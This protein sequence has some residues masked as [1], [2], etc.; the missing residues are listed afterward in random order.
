MKTK[1]HPTNENMNIITNKENINP[2]LNY[3]PNKPNLLKKNTKENF[4]DEMDQLLNADF[5]QKNANR[6]NYPQKLNPSKNKNNI[7][8]NPFGINVN[9]NKG[10]NNLTNFDSLMNMMNN[11]D[12]M[13]KSK[14]FDLLNKGS[15]SNNIINSNNLMNVVNQPKQENK[16]STIFST[17][18]NN[19]TN[20]FFSNNNNI[21]TKNV[22]L[23]NNNIFNK[24]NIDLNNLSNLGTETKNRFLYNNANTS[25]ANIAKNSNS[26]LQLLNPNRPEEKNQN[27]KIENLDIINSYDVEEVFGSEL[28]SKKPPSPSPSSGDDAEKSF[29]NQSKQVLM[30]TFP[31]SSIINFP[32][33]NR[34]QDECFDLLYRTDERALITSPTGSGKTLLFELGIGRIIKQ[35]Y[36]IK[37][38]AYKNK[39]FKIIYIAPI[40]S[41]CQE[42]TFEWKMKYG[43]AP[44]ELTVTESTSDSEYLNINLLNN[45]NIILTTPEKFD[46]LTR[47]W[48]DISNFISNISLLLI[49]EIHLLNEEHRGATLEAIIA[50]IKLL[51]NMENFKQTNLEHIRIIAVSATIPNITDVAEFLEI[52]G[53]NNKGL[54]IFGEEYRPVKVE[55]IVIGYKRNKNQNEFVFEKYLDYRVSSIIEKYSEG[56]PTLIFCQT[57]K[58]SI[59]SA[60]QLMA[61]Y[62]EGK[63]SSMKIDLP[64]KKILEQISSSINNKQLSTFVKFGIAFHNAGLSLNDRQI[65]EENF[66][67]NAIKIICT[68]STLSQGV[69]L[70]AR[71]VIIKSTNC[72]KGHNIGYSEYT[73][74]E[75][76]QMCGRAGRPQFDNKGIAV[77]MTEAYKTQ[78]FEGVGCEKIESHLKPNIVEH[79]NAEIATGIINDMDT[80]LVWIKNT[81]MYIRMIKE[82]NLFNIRAQFGKNINDIIEQY[83]RNLIIKTFKDL[84]E[85]SLIEIKNDKKVSPLKL[86]KKMSKNYVRFE[87]MKVIDKMMKE[88][89]GRCIVGNQV[90]QQIIDV[91]SKSEEFRNLRSKIEERKTLNELNKEPISEIRFKLK[92]AID[93]GQKKAYLLIQSALSGKVLENWELRK[94]Q[95]EI[96]QTSERILNCIRQVYKDLDDCKGFILT[97]LMSKSLDKGMW[98]DSIYII[99]QLPRIG[100]KFSRLLYRAGYTSF[101]KLREESNPRVIE[102]ICGKNPPFGNIILDSARSLPIINFE[103]KIDFYKDIYKII[104]E[105]NC[106]WNKTSSYT[107]IKND[108]NEYFDSYSTYHIVTADSSGSNKIIFNKKIRPSQ[109]SFKLFI[110]GL[111]EKQFPINIFFISDKFLGLDKILSIESKDD[112]KGQIFSLYN[113]NLNNIINKMNSLLESKNYNKDDGTKSKLSKSIMKDLENQKVIE[114]EFDIKLNGASPSPSPVPSRSPTPEKKIKKKKKIIRKKNKK[115]EFYENDTNNNNNATP[116]FNSEHKDI[117]NNENNNN[118]EDKSQMKITNFTTDKK[119]IEENNK[120]K[121]LN[122]SAIYG[123]DN[124]NSGGNKMNELNKIKKSKKGKKVK[125]STQNLINDLNNLDKNGNEYDFEFLNK[126][127]KFDNETNSMFDLFTAP[128]KN[129]NNISSDNIFDGNNLMM[130]INNNNNNKKENNENEPKSD[131]GFLNAIEDLNKYL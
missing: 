57:Q 66:K 2:L 80:A 55:R 104:L 22:S 11:V 84:S 59:N 106:K 35:N 28:N 63:L 96:C 75:I 18:K 69:N 10:I 37:E 101:E 24:E 125:M 49:D 110:N 43:K 44:L 78:K 51:K 23:N 53:N 97:I 3:T 50:R 64:T 79:I 20:N 38:K 62:Q 46:V 68:T 67:I 100:D 32:T 102:N 131:L 14:G 105:I 61:D 89:N 93:S 113:E 15:L 47:K 1:I 76:D 74:M 34:V 4:F 112:K 117:I 128:K 9:N 116:E 48:K 109:K 7:Y 58:G 70:P 122:V 41:L 36:N 123:E 91:L 90:I 81:F 27:E 119:N 129:K 73:K 103:Y 130:N 13:K 65:I 33:L 29:F 17:N 83:L 99:K 114:K 71:L 120:N 31:L 30:K 108:I 26:I 56:K 94:Q 52:K 40:K 21:N 95:N 118:N 60:K 82:P 12:N 6:T 16:L 54:K 19:T 8:N 92:G 5:W 107:Y 25:H 98:P 85:S 111:K 124:V 121:K 86:C 77:I 45:S 127:E 88:Q 87:T 126:Y 115:N 42:K 72:Y 39:N